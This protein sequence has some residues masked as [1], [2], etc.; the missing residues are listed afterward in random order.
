MS[1][2]LTELGKVSTWTQGS[3]RQA[4]GVIIEPTGPTATTLGTLRQ[5]RGVEVDRTLERREEDLFQGKCMSTGQS[6]FIIPRNA[7]FPIRRIKNIVLGLTYLIR[8]LLQSFSI[9]RPIRAASNTCWFLVILDITNW[10]RLTYS[11]TKIQSQISIHT[12]TARSST[13]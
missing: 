12:F 6:M 4:F 5:Q 2:R 10:K 9:H 3:C 13:I 1:S 7:C 11:F 8:Y